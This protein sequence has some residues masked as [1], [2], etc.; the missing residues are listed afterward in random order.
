MAN[1]PS[2]EKEKL[3]WEFAKDLHKGQ[4]RKFVGLPYFDAHVQK[5]NGI[6]K[7][8]TSDEDLIIA[9]LLHDTLE[10]CYEDP[11]VGYIQIKEMFGERVA[12]IVKELTYSKEEIEY[13]YGGN[14]TDYLID[15]M[16]NMSDDALTVKLADRLQNIA[17]AFTASEKFRNKYFEETSKIISELEGHRKFNKPQNSLIGEIKAKL[18]NIKS[19]FKIKRYDEF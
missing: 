11:D 17:D 5:V 1:F 18:D 7:Q 9:S 10:D 6:V 16:I 2:T 12:N 8:Y 15:K 19:I 3:A 13:E 14:K 4:V